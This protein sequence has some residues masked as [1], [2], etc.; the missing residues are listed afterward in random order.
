M[1][2]GMSASPEAVA[3]RAQGS[4][5][6]DSGFVSW[7]RTLNQLDGSDLHVKV[8][9]PPMVRLGSVLRRL[10]A[11]PVTPELAEDLAWMLVPEKRRT[12]LDLD[13]AVDFAHSEPGVGRYR[14]N[15]FRQRGSLTMVFRRLQIGGQTFGELGLPQ[16]VRTLAEENRGLVLVTGPTG[17]GKTTTLAAMVQHI[18]QTK[19]VHVVTI[20]DPIEVLFE[21]GV[22]SVNQREVGEDCTSFLQAIRSAM[23]QDPDVILIGEMRDTET[24]QAAMQAAETGHLVLSTLHTLD[25]AET[26]NRV[27]DFFPPHQQQQIRFALSSTLRGIVCQR[28]VPSVNGGRVPSLEILVNTGRVAQRIQDPA[29]T[30]EIGEVI[31][32]GEYYGMCTF[33]QSLVRLVAEG[34]VSP[35]QAMEAASNPHDLELMLKQSGVIDPSVTLERGR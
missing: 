28:L 11:P 6:P 22:A 32:E 35:E 7:L 18:S 14:G 31:A 17:S 29:I 10:D 1:H 15:I 21:D 2:R 13:G 26:V 8:G 12:I 23:R 33:D 4:G 5:G 30:M 34:R 19:P 16:T 9:S 3:L 24:V 25:A 27:V 20:E